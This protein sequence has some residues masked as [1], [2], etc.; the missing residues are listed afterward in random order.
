[1]PAA[2]TELPT[3]LSVDQELHMQRQMHGNAKSKDPLAQDWALASTKS[4]RLMVQVSMPAAGSELP[5]ALG[6]DH[7]LYMQPQ[8][9]GDVHSR[10][11]LGII[12]PSREQF[13]K[14]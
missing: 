7:R 9:H 2:S 10:E 5:T 11:P 12:A 8:M 1:M 13:T 14:P 3:A 4:G 6:L